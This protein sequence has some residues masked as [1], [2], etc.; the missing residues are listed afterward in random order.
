MPVVGA[1]WVR[2]SVAD[3]DGAAALAERAVGLATQHRDLPRLAD[4]L[5]LG[6]L[7]R[8]IADAH[9]DDAQVDAQ[10]REAGDIW[11][12]LDNPLRVLTNEIVVSR[13]RRDRLTATVARDELRSRGVHD[14]IWRVA[15]PLRAVARAPGADEIR[16]RVLGQFG[17]ELGG[18]ALPASAWPSRKARDVLRVLACR[19]DRGISRERLGSLVWPDVD[20]VGNRLSVALSHVRS[21]L[22]PGRR[23]TDSVVVS[24]GGV[25]R[26]DLRYVSVDLVDFTEAARAALVAAKAGSARAVPLLEGAAAMHTGELLE[27]AEGVDSGDWMLAEREEVELLGR[28]VLHALAELL[29]AGDEPAEALHWYARLLAHDPYDEATYAALITLLVRLGRYGEARRHHRTYAL[30]MDEL[31]VHAKSWDELAGG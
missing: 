14:D 28:E 16:V 15:G 20:A 12:Q 23:L 10:L 13:R 17:V 1:G 18:V 3:A 30:R 8:A 31:G 6:A 19:G 4:A 26:L 9:G 21:V 2:L 11:R 5:E 25:V 29:A 22:D 7:A 24:D 27:D